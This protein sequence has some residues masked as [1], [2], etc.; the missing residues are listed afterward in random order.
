[1]GAAE[2]KRLRR[3]SSLYMS[4]AGCI[5]DDRMPLD[6]P[7]VTTKANTS[8]FQAVVYS[9][10]AIWVVIYASKE[11]ASA[12]ATKYKALRLWMTRLIYDHCLSRSISHLSVY[13]ISAR[14][15]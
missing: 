5:F 2:L 3:L 10:A 11:R 9:K 14:G 8:I 13:F 7:V 6:A 1:V 12:E 15:R 4:H